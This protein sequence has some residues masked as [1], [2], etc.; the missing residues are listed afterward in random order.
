MMIKYGTGR[1]FGLIFLLTVFTLLTGCQQRE[2]A[3]CGQPAGRSAEIE[4]QELNF[5]DDCYSTYIEFQQLFN[6]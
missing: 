6:E 3:V 2:C 1:R 4:G 5:C